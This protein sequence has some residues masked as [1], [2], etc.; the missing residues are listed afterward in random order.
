L[1][2]I[3][4]R[5]GEKGGERFLLLLDRKLELLRKFPDIGSRAGFPKLRKIRVARTPFA[6]FYAVEGKRLMIIAIQDLRQDPKDLA[7]VIR[8]RL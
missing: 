1:D 4:L 7:R 8:S 3:Y 2:D 6:A 5:L